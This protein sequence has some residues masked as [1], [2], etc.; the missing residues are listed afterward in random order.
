MVL[1]ADRALPFFAVS[2]LTTGRFNP[3]HTFEKHPTSGPDTAKSPAELQRVAPAPDDRMKL[4][5]S[6]SDWKRYRKALASTEQASKDTIDKHDLSRFLKDLD[7]EGTAT[8]DKDGSI[9]MDRC[10]DGE[11]LRVGLSASNALAIDSNPQLAYIFFL[12]RTQG[13]LKSPKHSRETMLEFDQDWAMLQ[14][15]ALETDADLRETAAPAGNV[16]AYR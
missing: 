9:W 5:G 14:H 10:E 11:P 6:A 3:E 13:V 4:V 15:V 12:A 2:Y 1:F 7:R 8:V 16:A